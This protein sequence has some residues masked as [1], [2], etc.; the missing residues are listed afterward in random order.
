MSSFVPFVIVSG[1]SVLSRRVKHGTPSTVVSSVMPPESVI[2]PRACFNARNRLVALVCFF[3]L[4]EHD[5]PDKRHTKRTGLLEDN[6]TDS[7]VFHN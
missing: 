2:T 4:D 3:C 6:L 5:E 7:F 1:R